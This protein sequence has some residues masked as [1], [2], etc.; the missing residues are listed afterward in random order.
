VIGNKLSNADHSPRSSGPAGAQ[1]EVK[2]ATHYA[3][4]LLA[5]TEAFGLP[6]AIAE[7]IAFQ[8]GAQGHPLDD[9]IVKGITMCGEAQVLDL[10]AKRSIAFTASDKN[11]ASIVK[12]IVET[13]RNEPDGRNRHYAVAIERTSGPIEHGVQEVLELARS[14]ECAEVFFSLLNTPGRSNP[15][16]RQFVEAVRTHLNNYGVTDEVELFEILAR[17]SVLVFD[18]ARPNSIAEAHDRMRAKALGST[19]VDQGLYDSLLGHIMRL[20]SIGGGKTR[21][22][23]VAD[24]QGLGV[25]LAGA[26]QLVKAR[27]RLDEMSILALS[28]INETVQDVSLTRARRNQEIW[29]ALDAAALAGGVVEILGPGGVG[30]S[31]LLKTQ[32]LRKLQACRILV[33][34]PDRIPPGGWQTLRQTLGID[35]DGSDFF[36]D[37]ACDGGGI[38]CIDSLD[39]IHASGEQKTVIDVLR[40]ATGTPGV[41]VLFTARP[42][43]DGEP[44]VWLPDDVRRSLASRR[45]IIVDDLDDDEA[46]A[47]GTAA[48]ELVPL[49]K[50]DSPVRPLAR[51]LFILRRLASMRRSVDEVGSEAQLAADWWVTGGHAL[52][53]PPSE[54]RARRRVLATVARTNL[55]GASLVDVSGLDAEAVEN[56]VVGE[57]LVE[58]GPTDRVKFRHDL[59]FD[60]ALG[61]FLSDDTSRIDALA[62][63]TLPPHWLSRAFELACRRL[64]ESTEEA[65]YIALLDRLSE[66]SVAPGWLGLALLALVRSELGTRLLEKYAATLLYGDGARGAAL[67]HRALAA[68]GRPAAELLAGSLPEDVVL[69]DGITLPLDLVWAQLSLWS[70]LRFDR[71]PT[72]TLTAALALYEQWMT[73]SLF[74]EDPITPLLLERVADLLVTHIEDHDQPIAPLVRGKTPPIRYPIGDEGVRTARRMIALYALRAPKAATRYL[75]AVAASERAASH[76]HQILEFAGNLPAAAPASFAAAILKAIEQDSK[77]DDCVS[78]S[79]WRYSP[80]LRLDGPF[81]LGQAGIVIFSTLLK[82][83]EGASF[84]L[85]RHL[86]RH[87]EQWVSENADGFGIEL[88]GCERR[89]APVSSYGWSRGF[90][91]S[92]LLSKALVALEQWGHEAIE[93]GRPLEDIVAQILGEGEI[94]GALFL[95]AVDL[96][97]SHGNTTDRVLWDLIV[98]P[99][100]LALDAT[101]SH[102][103]TADRM[104]GGR[105]S[106]II[107]AKSEA[108]RKTIEELSA[109]PSRALALHEAIPQVIW[110]VEEA[111]TQSLR[112]RLGA[113]VKRLGPWDHENVDW[114]SPQFMASHA[115]RQASREC[116]RE[117]NAMDENGCEAKGW[118]FSWPEPQRRWL[119]TQSAKGAAAQQFFSKA[120]AVRMAMNDDRSDVKAT[121]EDAIEV[122]ADTAAAQPGDADELH[123][124]EDPWIN[125]IAAAAFVTRHSS[126]GMLRAYRPELTAIFNQALDLE[127]EAPRH[128]Q[129]QLMYDPKAL[130]TTGQLYLASRSGD[131]DHIHRLLNAI[132]HHTTS[133]AAAFV[134]HG[135]ATKSLGA[136]TVQA[137]VRIGIEACMFARRLHFEEEPQAYVDRKAVADKKLSDRLVAE[138]AW[139]LDAG[140]AP[141]WPCPP[142]R[143][144]RRPRRSLRLPNGTPKPP[145]RHREPEWPDF[146]FDDRTA[147]EWTRCLSPLGSEASESVK[148]L[149]SANRDWLISTNSVN[150]EADE[151]DIERTWTRALMQRIAEHARAWSV[152]ERRDLVFDILNDFSDEAFIDAAATFLVGSDLQ[153]IEGSPDDTAY[154]EELRRAI[155]TKL[156]NTRHWHRHRQSS[157]RGMEIH[158]KELMSALFFTVSS[159]FGDGQRYTGGLREEQLAPFLPILT[160]IAI[161][162]GACPTTALLFLKAF[163][164]LEPLCVAPFVANAAYAWVSGAD[165]RF[166]SD[167]GIGQR[168][169]R[170]LRAAQTSPENATQISIIADAICASGVT[171]GEALQA[172]IRNATR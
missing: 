60:W 38:V 56:L 134:G 32:A 96:T 17:F 62:L 67:I 151:S 53:V 131:R 3:L 27:A 87:A 48:P 150:E 104:T 36:A 21:A 46:A 66:D 30:K 43:R 85:I 157:S 44:L 149:V 45:T 73:V 130:A 122:L 76:L 165:I 126:E 121:I 64:A 7:E 31:A 118:I 167:L 117:E 84:F 22:G 136:R 97:L 169:C 72:K 5:R 168:V 9:V 52:D 116:Y 10:Q 8:R 102:R 25:S 16:M 103:D 40:F 127:A 119:E 77:A 12:A 159:G 20:D 162:A 170:I 82:A 155:W 125:R 86:L 120:L 137:A 57:V 106:S 123:D 124:P 171:E 161:D 49:L 65:A 80:S 160:E 129:G 100:A 154:L 47:L 111:Q 140:E 115:L 68:H 4:A 13:R 94:S 81:V 139:L 41:T 133:A 59:F 172:A 28:D 91:P 14:V 24:L 145:L 101:R 148:E 146:Y 35:A 166:W 63:E 88:F 105:L 79:D 95:I 15:D 152:E 75:Q 78:R 110:S 55:D 34:A 112:D 98:S 143:R 141:S 42:N 153:H 158:L 54:Q 29:E 2:V 147:A 144:A 114:S 99:E 70:A 128:S 90:G 163:E 142:P 51:N 19:N 107:G 11:L 37:L 39:R 74:G 135:A 61:C 83:D 138:E 69:P 58:L 71:L 92:V 113:G 33:L 89:V 108:E 18:Y 132:S 23:L 26:P 6:G 1:F 109:R 156:K 93:S 164:S 50:T